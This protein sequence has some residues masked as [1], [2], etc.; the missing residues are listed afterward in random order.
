MK[1]IDWYVG[2]GL[3][4]ISKAMPVMPLGG[5]WPERESSGEVEGRDGTGR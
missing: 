2:K 5:G 1:R 4:G 3:K